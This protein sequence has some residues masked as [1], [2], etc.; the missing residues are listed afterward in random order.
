LWE[1]VGLISPARSNGR[2]R[3]YSAELLDVLKRIK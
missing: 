2:Y 1:S 3:L